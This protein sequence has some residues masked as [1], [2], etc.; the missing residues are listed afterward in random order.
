MQKTETALTELIEFTEFL[1][2]MPNTELGFTTAD[3]W[4]KWVAG[5]VKKKA[6]SLLQKEREDM[7]K[8][9]KD[10]YNEGTDDQREGVFQFDEDEYFDNT[11]TQYNTK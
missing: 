3:Q 5:I 1:N 8:T 9:A 10:A 11:F 7:V 4:V 6:I 2:E